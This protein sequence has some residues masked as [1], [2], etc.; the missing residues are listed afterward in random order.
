MAGGLNRDER[1]G[2]GPRCL[3]FLVNATP[4]HRLG[5]MVAM[6]TSDSRA[7]AAAA[8]VAGR[9]AGSQSHGARCVLR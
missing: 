8:A 3:S 5:Y 7:A 1:E 4:R 6:H 2:I 9:Q